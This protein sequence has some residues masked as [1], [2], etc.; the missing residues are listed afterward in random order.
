[1]T[2]G[3]SVKSPP[4]N[5]EPL[6]R[7]FALAPDRYAFCIIELLEAERSVRYSQI[8]TRFKMSSKTLSKRLRQ[9][10]SL[11]AI[12]RV[13]FSEIPPRVEYRLT[14]SGKRLAKILKGL[15]AWSSQNCAA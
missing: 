7:L 3:R 8:Q 6:E 2:I 14:P 12:E 15:A 11:Q 4:K 9:L 10:I 5:A 13:A 1:M